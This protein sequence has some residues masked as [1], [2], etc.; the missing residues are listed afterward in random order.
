MIELSTLSPVA[1][2]A[3]LSDWGRGGWGVRASL[4]HGST[5]LLFAIGTAERMF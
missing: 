5:I 2:A 3:P 1:A 4:L